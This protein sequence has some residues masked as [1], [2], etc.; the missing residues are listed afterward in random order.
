MSSREH[1]KHDQAE[2]LILMRGILLATDAADQ[3]E[4]CV[5]N[6]PERLEVA[7]FQL[8]RTFTHRFTRWGRSRFHG[9]ALAEGDASEDEDRNLEVQERQRHEM[10]NVYLHHVEVL[11]HLFLEGQAVPFDLQPLPPFALDDPS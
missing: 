11:G 9:P 8:D 2:A 3:M 10:N 5:L 7:W 6:R 1:P 4:P